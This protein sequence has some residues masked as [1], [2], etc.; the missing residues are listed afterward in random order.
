MRPVLRVMSKNLVSGVLHS[1]HLPLLHPSPPK[2]LYHR[3]WPLESPAGAGGRTLSGVGAHSWGASLLAGSSRVDTVL[4]Q[5]LSLGA[6]LTTPHPPPSM[7]K[8]LITLRYPTVPSCPQDPNTVQINPLL[9]S[10][11]ASLACRRLPAASCVPRSCRT[12]HLQHTFPTRPQAHLLSSPSK[13]SHRHSHH[14]G[15]QEAHSQD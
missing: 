14:S 4:Y 1:S 3:I 5:R 6:L 2:S 10:Q 12:G 9:N 7:P 15:Q 11:V 13:A 8:V